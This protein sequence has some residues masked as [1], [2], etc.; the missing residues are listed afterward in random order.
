L[1]RRSIGATLIGAYIIVAAGIPLPAAKLPGKNGELFPCA[2][3]GCGC[4]SAEKCW[5]SCCCHTLAERLAWA[6][7]NGVQPPDFALAEAARSGLDATGKPL[8]AKLVKVALSTKTCCHGK[9]K[10]CESAAKARTCCSSPDE[11]Q[12]ETTFVVAWRA[13]GCHG[14]S[15]H[16]LAA[17][18]TLIAVDLNL[19]D[20]LP[21]ITWLGPHFSEIARGVSDT[22]TPPPPERA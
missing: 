7:K 14:Q 15:L 18:P 21:R 2:A 20:Q 3:S 8:A 16:W 12:E 6:A 1:L 5:R 11:S 9:H 10:C 22:P 4:N 17:V 13:L 19:S